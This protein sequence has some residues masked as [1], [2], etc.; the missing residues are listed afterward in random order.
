MS[1]FTTLPSELTDEI[2]SRISRTDLLNTSLTCRTLHQKSIRSINRF[3]KISVRPETRIQ[4]TVAE[5]LFSTAFTDVSLECLREIEVVG[6]GLGGAGSRDIAS[7][8]V[9]LVSGEGSV[10]RKQ[11]GYVEAEAFFNVRLRELLGRLQPGQIRAFSYTLPPPQLPLNLLT[12]KFFEPQTL[13]A[14]FAPENRLTKLD[15]TFSHSISSDCNVFNLPHLTTFTSRASDYTAHYHSLFSI[16]FNTQKTLRELYCHNE[17]HISRPRQRTASQRSSESL[18]FMHDGFAE[19]KQCTKCGLDN[20]PSVPSK[21]R[22]RLTELRVWRIDGLSHMMTEVFGPY[23]VVQGSR[24]TDVEIA[25]GSLAFVKLTAAEGGTLELEKL[26]EHANGT[27]I[28]PSSQELGTYFG[29][30]KGLVKVTLNFHRDIGFGWLEA[31]KGSAETLRELHFSSVYGNMVVTEDEIEGLG[32]SLQKLE[33]LTVSSDCDLPICIMN[34]STFPRLR[35]FGNRAYSN[36]DP[37]AKRRLEDFMWS[38]SDQASLSTSIR[39]ICFRLPGQ[40][41]LIERTFPN[42]N[43]GSVDIEIINV[44]DSKVPG[45]LEGLGEAPRFG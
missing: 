32:R 28:S 2:F 17:R 38:N 3:L 13:S 29:C 35:Y 7:R 31:L 25:V 40:N 34:S 36:F 33:M 16:L 23:N 45:I 42:G 6:V 39:L 1:G 30:T 44:D 37:G 14:L 41:Y 10:G 4:E 9:Y 43:N 26:L 19:W 24:L 5:K 8:H 21:R 18:F 15:I 12:E 20:P 27:Q 11:E 22:I